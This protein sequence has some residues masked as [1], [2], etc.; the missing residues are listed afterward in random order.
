VTNDEF[1]NIERLFA[2]LPD[3]ESREAA[4]RIMAR[5]AAWAAPDCLNSGQLVSGEQL[6]K[7]SRRPMDQTVI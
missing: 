2:S 7:D 4:L 1:H 3:R 5:E 6:Q